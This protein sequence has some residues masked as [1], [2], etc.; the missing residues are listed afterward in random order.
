MIIHIYAKVSK[1]LKMTKQI[2][3]LFAVLMMV[4][5]MIVTRGHD[6]WLSSM[7]HLPDFTIP[8]LFIA[9]VYFRKFWV[10]FTLILSSVAI[11]NY[12]IVHQGVSAHCITP[13]YSLLPLTYYGIFWISKA[14]STLVIDDN[15]VKNA[16][17]IIIA[18][19]TQWFAATSSY[20]FFTTT[21][22]QTGWRDFPA[23]VAKWSM[24]EIPTTLSWMA[25]IIITFTLV[26]RISPALKLQKSD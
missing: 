1:G 24:I 25:I 10:V 3:T 8:A 18:T 9:G 14:I 5:L 2:N 7:L 11:D 13:A 16:F 20:Y 15:I 19:C 12:A 17:V 6:N 4:L 21:Y 23:Y 22:S 26:P